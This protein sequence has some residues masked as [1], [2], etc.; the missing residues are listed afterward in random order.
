MC[1][2]FFFFSFFKKMGVIATNI[3][4]SAIA[5]HLL[6][7]DVEDLHPLAVMLWGCQDYT[8]INWDCSIHHVYRECNM[9]ADGLAK[10]GSCLDLGMSTFHDPLDSIRSFLNKDLFGVCRPRAI[11]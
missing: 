8:D 5:V 3:P 11:V 9:V 4:H 6:N 2:F 10:L 1:F 7:K